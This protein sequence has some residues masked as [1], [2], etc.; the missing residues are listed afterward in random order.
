M[1]EF[2]KKYSK[3]I[4]LCI[5]LGIFGFVV[6]ELL[7]EKLEGFDTAVYNF[8]ISIKSPFF[9]TFFKIIT[10]LVSPIFLII[11]KFRFSILYKP[12]IK[13]S[14]RKTKTI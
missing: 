13:I 1:K 14:F 5:L 3:W 4:I 9:T 2:I 7:T 10:A 8:V 12:N 6:M 11:R